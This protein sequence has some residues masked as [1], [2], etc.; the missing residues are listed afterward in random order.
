MV[1]PETARAFAPL[2]AALA[3]P[4][5]A[6]HAYWHL[7]LSGPAALPS[8]RR[9]LTHESADVRAYCARALDHLVDETAYPALIAL[10]DD[11]DARV[12]GEAL[13]ALACDRCKETSCRPEKNDVLPKALRLLTGHPEPR[14]RVLAAEVVARW[15]HTDREAAAGLE[16]ASQRDTDPAVRKKASWYAPGGTIYRKTAP[17]RVRTPS[18]R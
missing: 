14:V 1:A 15:V 18:G 13:H 9:G 4:H 5:R 16:M 17:K 11:A 2:I 12:R 6:K 7:V 10:L 8:V 3:I